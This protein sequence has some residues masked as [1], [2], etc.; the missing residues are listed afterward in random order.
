MALAIYLG[1][2]VTKPFFGEPGLVLGGD[3][4]PS[5]VQVPEWFVLAW[6]WLFFGLLRHHLWGVVLTGKPTTLSTQN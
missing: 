3:A 4:E 6:S 1:V 5:G 2:R